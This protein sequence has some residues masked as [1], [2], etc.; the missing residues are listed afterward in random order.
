[1][2][3]SIHQETVSPMIAWLKE[4]RGRGSRDE[5]KLRAILSM[6]DYSVEFRRYSEPNLPVC[7]IRFEE[8]VDFFLHFDE[9]NFENPRLASKK[10]NFLAFYHDLDSRMQKMKMLESITPEDLRLVERLLEN[11][12][13]DSLMAE[14]HHFTVLLT[15]SIGNSMGWPYGEYIHF[16]VANT[17]LRLMERR[18][19]VCAK[20]DSEIVGVLLFQKDEA[21]CVFWLLTRHIEG[22]IL[23]RNCSR[24]RSP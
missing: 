9:K 23:P 16:D 10:E 7:G 22:G 5:R 13:P 18:E 1:M 4:A 15:V 12:L 11:G 19:A 20:M 2:R 3:I 14:I 24:M 17:V 21:N 8:A 6:P